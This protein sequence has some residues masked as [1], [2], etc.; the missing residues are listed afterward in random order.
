MSIDFSKAY[1]RISRPKLFTLLAKLG[2]GHIMLRAIQ[3]M[4]KSTKNILKTAIINSKIGIKQ[5]GSSSGLLFILY[6][7]ILAKMLKAA[8]PTDGFLDPLHSLML[9]DDTAILATSRENML[10]RYD[11]SVQFCI[12]YDMVI[13]EDKTKF[14]VINGRAEDKRSFS[15]G[16]LT[17][18]HTDT[19]I[20]LGSSFSAKGCISTDIQDHAKLKQKHINKFNIF[21][22]KNQSKP[23]KYKKQVF[24]AVLT[25]KLIYGCEAWLTEDYHVIETMYMSALKTLLGVRKQTPN[26]I[27]L[28]EC[29]VP[30]LKE[31]VR[32]K[33]QNFIK[34]KLTDPEEPL[35]I[36]YNLC[37]Q[38]ETNAYR[39]LKKALEFNCDAEERRHIAM[40]ESTKTKTVTY[41]KI[42]PSFCVHSMYT[43]SDHYVA[44]YR[45][46]EMTRFRVGSHRLIV[47]TGR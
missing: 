35:T 17:I 39:N 15:K 45:R 1:D 33:Q 38:N 6:M 44:D 7:D 5:G 3:A 32:V 2:C 43:S 42:N 46:T 13:N 12:E 28:T 21:C 11:A 16:G 36:V 18:D 37:E 20:Y 41:R 8:C 30:T 25:I 22:F 34:S 24:E 14:M 10:K 9:M 31:R 40:R 47:E 27:V 23:F 26:D 19:Y 29:G 4:Y